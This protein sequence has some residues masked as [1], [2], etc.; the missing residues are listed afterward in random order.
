MAPGEKTAGLA[1]PGDHQGIT[2]PGGRDEQQRPCSHQLALLARR[3][4]TGDVVA[5]DRRRR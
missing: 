1:I 5:G 3:V 2:C 4:I